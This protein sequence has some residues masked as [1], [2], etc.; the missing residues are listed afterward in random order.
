MVIFEEYK[1]LVEPI[2]DEVAE[3]ER[4]RRIKVDEL[5]K[6]L[7]ELRKIFELKDRKKIDELLDELSKLE[8]VD[9]FYEDKER[10]NS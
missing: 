7:I 2:I 8:F 5:K 4:N 9:W 1:K 3:V 6:E 10:L